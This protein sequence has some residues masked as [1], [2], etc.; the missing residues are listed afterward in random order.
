MK[1][2]CFNQH[3]LLDKCVSL[4]ILKKNFII[5]HDVN[6]HL[7]YCKMTDLFNQRKIIQYSF[8]CQ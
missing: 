1:Y 8:A 6:N 4:S 3:I 5:S 7:K 2:I